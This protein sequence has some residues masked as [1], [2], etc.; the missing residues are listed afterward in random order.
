MSLS[1]I[2][3]NFD[4]VRG[5]VAVID[6]V[7]MNSAS[8][9]LGTPL[10]RASSS[11]VVQASRESPMEGAGWVSVQ[12]S[13]LEAQDRMTEES[14]TLIAISKEEGESEEESTVGGW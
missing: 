7:L 6:N 2:C 12:G 5:D 11:Q 8:P 10:C 9:N 14:S 1:L 3:T 13:K 4:L